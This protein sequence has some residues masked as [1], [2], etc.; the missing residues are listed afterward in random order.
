MEF[1]KS[2]IC[3]GILASSIS[4]P[5][6]A[7][8]SLWLLCD[9]GKLVVNVLEHRDGPDS[10]ASSLNLILGA[11]VFSGEKKDSAKGR[12]VLRGSTDKNDIFNGNIDIDF[13]SR[14]LKIQGDL[15]IFGSQHPI[16]SELQC[17]EITSEI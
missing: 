11:H 5:A 13:I 14:T 10:R 16:Q 4:A 17:K 3:F 15:T 7:R 1:L 6:F 2:A 9:D 12:L 8:D